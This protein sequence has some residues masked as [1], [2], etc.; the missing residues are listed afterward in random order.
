MCLLKTESDREQAMDPGSVDYPETLPIT[1]IRL[2]LRNAAEFIINV[3]NQ[4]YESGVAFWPHVHSCI[5]ASLVISQL[6]LLEPDINLTTFLADAYL[7]PIFRSFE[8]EEL[9]EV[10]VD[11]VRVDK[12]Q[13][14]GDNAQSQTSDD[15]SSPSPPHHPTTSLPQDV[16]H[17]G[18]PPQYA[19]NFSSSTHYGYHYEA[20]PGNS[21]D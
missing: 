17:H 2:V 21:R 15:H 7:H 10:R 6:L 5:I 20:E 13:S 3:Y 18:F 12:N 14:Y 8:E 9:V 19:Y 4:Q 1:V 16:Y 11:Q